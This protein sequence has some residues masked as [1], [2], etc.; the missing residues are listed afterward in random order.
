MEDANMKWARALTAIL[1]V[2]VVCT[3]TTQANAVTV[4]IDGAVKH[5]TMDGFGG[6]ESWRKPPASMYTRIFDDLGVSILRFQMFAYTEST[7]DQP[8]DR[9]ADNDNDDPFSIDWNGVDTNIIGWCASLLQAAQS[10]GV[11][12]IGTTWSPP[13]WMKNNNLV[14][15]SSTFKSGYEDELVEFIQIWVEGMERYHGVHVDSVTIQNEPDNLPPWPG[16]KYTPAQLRDIIKLLGAR[17]AAEGITTEIHAPD[18]TSLNNFNNSYADTICQDPVAKGYVDQL[19]THPYWSS[20]GNPDSHINGWIAAHNLASGYGK[21]LWQTEYTGRGVGTFPS[22]AFLLVQH[23]H[24]A[25]VY[26]HVSAWLCYELYKDGG[27]SDGVIGDSGPYPRFYALKQYYRYVRPGAVRVKAES[28]NKDILATSFIHEQDNTFTIVVINRDSSDQAVD[29]DMNNLQALST[30]DV[31]RTSATEKSVNLGQLSV[32]NNAFTCALPRESITTFT[33]PCAFVSAIIQPAIDDAND[34]DT[35][36]IE[37]GHYYESVDLKGKNLTLTSTKPND[38]TVVVATVIDGGNKAVT[39]S[40]GE[41]PTCVLAGL[42]ITGAKTGIYCSGTSPTIANCCVTGNSGTGIEMRNGSK[43]TI[44]NCSIVANTGNG[45]EMRPKVGGRFTYSNY[46]IIT[47][48]IIAGNV[49]HGIW[50]GVPTIANCTIVGN[51]RCGISTPMPTVTNSVVHG[52]GSSSNAVQIES[53]FAAVSYSNVQ[54]SWPG[55]G[56]IEADPCF[57]SP[58]YW[59]DAD[60][61]HVSADS[62][63]LNAIWVDGDYHLRS[64]AG[65]W[66]PNSQS[67]VKD[68]VTSLCI[69]AGDPNSDWTAEL[70]PHGQRINIGAYGGTPQAGMSLSSIGNIADLNNDDSVDCRDMTILTN[71]WLRQEVLLFEDLDRNGVVGIKD[72]CIFADNW[73]WEQ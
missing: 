45:I 64:Q 29:F 54:G 62:N 71:E 41:G 9:A 36:V 21:P 3:M 16:C 7:P 55:I 39:I 4:T 32:V 52:N 23:V 17:F 38:P 60:D 70:W 13:A 31:I 42:T 2:I 67:W 8:G 66:D 46:P 37:P 50:G 65:R 72:F 48:C 34:G 25:L 24:N 12:I 47:N 40:N 69:H 58:G 30:L 26:G 14:E 44:T 56:N 19:A 6:A 35:I 61:P 5:Q 15:S 22:D 63:D 53:D 49:Q 18:M 33:G 11:K 28:S 43:P 59:G 73:L 10:R 27:G 68:V 51:R 57:V 1:P 20:F